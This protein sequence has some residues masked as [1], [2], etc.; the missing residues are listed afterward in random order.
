MPLLTKKTPHSE[1]EF[2]FHYCGT[3]LHAVRWHQKQSGA[4]WKAHYVTPVF[5][6][7]GAVG[8]Y[9]ILICACEGDHVV[10]H[11][12]PLLFE[13]LADPSE[14]NPLD[15]HVDPQYK[16]VLNRIKTEVAE[17]QKTF[18]VVPLQFSFLNNVWRPW[19]QPCCGTFPFC[20]CDKEDRNVTAILG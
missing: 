14:S 8:C 4:I 11:D 12:P 7:E 5:F 18:S 16:A 15:P 2:L 1:H 10:H 9:D 19:L 6:P 20:W 17:H 13:L 3:S